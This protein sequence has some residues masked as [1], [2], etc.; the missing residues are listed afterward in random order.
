[1]ASGIVRG[2]LSCILTDS[3]FSR[4]S[5]RSK[6]SLQQLTTLLS[7]IEEEPYCDIFDEFASQLLT[8]LQCL[9]ESAH[10]ESF[11]VK[12]EYLWSTFHQKRV[13]DIARLWKNFLQSIKTE[14]DPL[15]TQL[16]FEGK[17]KTKFA[18]SITT[19]TNCTVP[20][21]SLSH[22]EECIVRYAAGYVPF[23]LLRKHEKCLSDYS[24]QIVECLSNMAICGEETDFLRYTREWIEQVNRGGL[25][26][27][28]DTA[29]MLFKEIEVHLQNNLQKH[30]QPTPKLTIDNDTKEKLVSS[31]VVGSNVQ[32]Y[33]YKLSVDIHDEKH[34][35]KLLAEIVEL[36]LSL[37]GHSIAGQWLE[38]YKNC[39]AK[40][41]K[42]SKALRKQLKEK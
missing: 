8:S 1:M 39:V 42:K 2:A 32:F 6:K 22:E 13:T 4:T 11:T 24:V 5:E 7:L 37:R 14:L 9:V 31:V 26:E 27:V 35:Q 20:L 15:V 12:R 21:K 23:V 41:T 19:T 10:S 36:W 17:I 16:L 3:T 29:Y 33:W 30:L 18:G 38:Y 25:F 28:N 34:S 40:N